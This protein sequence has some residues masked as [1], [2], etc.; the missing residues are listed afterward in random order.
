MKI[1]KTIK[2]KIFVELTDRDIEKIVEAHFLAIYPGFKIDRVSFETCQG[3][4]DSGSVSLE[5][6]EEVQE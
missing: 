6:I 2:E 1:S 3:C 5:K 4:L